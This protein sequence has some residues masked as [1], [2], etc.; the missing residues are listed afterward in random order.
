MRTIVLAM[1]VV[2]L[3]GSAVQAGG[4]LDI[5]YGYSKLMTTI[6]LG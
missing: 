2:C 5:S 4:S 3:A 6:G 1:L